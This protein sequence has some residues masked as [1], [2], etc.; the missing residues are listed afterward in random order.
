M[1][2]LS[3]MRESSTYLEIG[4]QEGKHF[5]GIRASHAIAVDPAFRINS[6]ITNGKDTVYMHCG[7]SD[8]FFQSDYTTCNLMRK[9]D[10]AFL[11]GLHLFEF[12]LRDFYNT[13][14]LSRPEGLIAMH[15]CL[16]LSAEMT[17]RDEKEAVIASEST[18]FRG[19]WT[20]DV[21]K[22]VPILHK[23]RPDLNVICTNAAPT[24]LVCVTNLDPTSSVL[25]D[26]YLDIVSEF[27]AIPNSLE[28]IEEFYC[29]L[30]IIDA[31]KILNGFDHSLYFRI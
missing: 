16:P 25:E 28:N 21:W 2:S 31:G 27:A 18:S 3:K 17:L 23:Y 13:E 20:G 1:S 8:S 26:R 12:L 7:T 14:A 22:I 29:N 6:N 10:L 4:V 19:A 24:G 5:S 9:I 15:D 30:K 11:D